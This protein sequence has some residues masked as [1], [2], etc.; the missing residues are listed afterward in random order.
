MQVRAGRLREPSKSINLNAKSI[1]LIHNP[2][3]LIQNPSI[4]YA[5][6]APPAH[7]DFLRSLDVAWRCVSR[8]FRVFSGS[9][10]AAVSVSKDHEIF[11]ESE[12]LCIK[13]EDFRITNDECLQVARPATATD[14]ASPTLISTANCKLNANFLWN[15]LVKME[16]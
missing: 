13:N 6:A 8:V 10:R 5:A 4:Q 11:I 12:K 3:I 15:F 2:S 14:R 7:L 1:D 16:R 9:P